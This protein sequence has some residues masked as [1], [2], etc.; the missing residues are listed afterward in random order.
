[1]TGSHS[2]ENRR[3]V[4]NLVLTCN[5]VNCSHSENQAE[6]RVKNRMTIW[7]LPNTELYPVLHPPWWQDIKHPIKF[8]LGVPTPTLVPWWKQ[9]LVWGA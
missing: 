3:L 5:Y 8:A 2:Y 7:E 4:L 1:M 9:K 6:N